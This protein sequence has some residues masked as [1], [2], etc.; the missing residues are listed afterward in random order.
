MLQPGVVGHEVGV[1]R[2]PE[3]EG[4]VL[5]GVAQHADEGDAREQHAAGNSLQA[6]LLSFCLLTVLVSF[7]TA[8][9]PPPRSLTVLPTLRGCVA[10][11]PPYQE[12]KSSSPPTSHTLAL[13]SIS[14]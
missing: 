7:S 4:V 2:D 8:A 14:R 10:T 6:E 11:L 13:P 9:L 1:V 3:L 5:R 12:K